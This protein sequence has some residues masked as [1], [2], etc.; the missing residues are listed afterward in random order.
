MPWYRICQFDPS[1][2]PVEFASER[3]V[4]G[5]ERKLM[6]LRLIHKS[7]ISR[8]KVF[9]DFLW[10]SLQEIYKNIP[11]F[12]YYKMTYEL[13]SKPY[14]VFQKF[15]R[16]FL[17]YFKWHLLFFSFITYCYKV[18]MMWT[19]HAGLLGRFCSAC[20]GFWEASIDKKYRCLN[21]ENIRPSK[22]AFLP[23]RKSSAQP[24]YPARKRSKPW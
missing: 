19:V 16:R 24:L 11:L 2:I 22:I 7:M 21:P 4:K 14:L 6:K 1:V 17:E 15:F 23:T 8:C 5:F 12:H 18:L 13:F 9:G 20:V 3:K 10:F